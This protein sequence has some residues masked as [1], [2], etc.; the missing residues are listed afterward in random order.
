MFNKKEK[1]IEK[2][3]KYW[4]LTIERNK[5]KETIVYQSNCLSRFICIENELERETHILYS[6]EITK[7]EYDEFVNCKNRIQYSI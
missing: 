3:W 5:K 1:E 2:T 6:L 7:D 4:L